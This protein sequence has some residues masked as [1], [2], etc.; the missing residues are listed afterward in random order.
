L[1]SLGSAGLRHTFC[2]AAL[3]LLL[4]LL[5]LLRLLLLLLQGPASKTGLLL[6]PAAGCSSQANPSL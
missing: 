6:S 3:R 1:Q 4:L 2:C 5:L